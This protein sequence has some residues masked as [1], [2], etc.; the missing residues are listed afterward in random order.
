[1]YR[2]PSEEDVSKIVID[3]N[4]IIGNSEPMLI[5]ENQD[6]QKVVTE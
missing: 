4:V 1:M 6:R 3:E 5:Y 2:I